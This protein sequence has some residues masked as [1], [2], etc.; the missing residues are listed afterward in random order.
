[1]ICDRCG[2]DISGTTYYTVDISAEDIR[3]TYDG[4]RSASTA[5]ANCKENLNKLLGAKR[6]YC[7]GCID[8]IKAFIF[9]YESSGLNY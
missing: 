7:K 5:T 8:Q 6:Q 4:T 3:P 2:R 9:N 1:M